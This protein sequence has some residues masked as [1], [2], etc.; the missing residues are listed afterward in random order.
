MKSSISE[1]GRLLALRKELEQA[2]TEKLLQYVFILLGVAISVSLGSAA[3]AAGVALTVVCPLITCFVLTSVPIGILVSRKLVR[4][5][6]SRK[7]HG[8]VVE[9]IGLWEELFREEVARIQAL[10][11]PDESK[12]ELIREAYRKSRGDHELLTLPRR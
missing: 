6:K 4:S 8:E 2:S 7:L 1:V 12:T 11:I 3:I 9:A 10:P 5:L